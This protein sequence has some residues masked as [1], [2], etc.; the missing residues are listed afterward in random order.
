MLKQC[1]Y[2]E[3]KEKERMLVA[4]TARGSVPENLYAIELAHLPQ[5]GSIDGRF[6]WGKVL[7]SVSAL[8]CTLLA[9]S[10]RVYLAHM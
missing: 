7:Q 10:E 3:R 9:G 4:M 6:H 5:T 8:A 2:V 1:L